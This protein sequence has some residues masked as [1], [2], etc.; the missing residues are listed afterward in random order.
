MSA[1][2]SA[3]LPHLEEV[4]PCLQAGG[5][6]GTGPSAKGSRNDAPLATGGCLG[7]SRLTTQ[8]GSL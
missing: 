6:P 8:M 2:N 4:R 7:D 3:L 1:P 5:R